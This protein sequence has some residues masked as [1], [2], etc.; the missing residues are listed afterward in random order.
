[1]QDVFVGSFGFQ[2][3]GFG[4]CGLSVSFEPRALGLEVITCRTLRQC[5][6]RRRRARS[7]FPASD[8]GSRVPLGSK[9]QGLGLKVP[10]LGGTK[11]LGLYWGSLCESDY[12]GVIGPG[13]LNQ[14]PTLYGFDFGF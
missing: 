12:F 4:I 13:F 9:L 14:V 5:R 2:V 1:M 10:G 3:F 11:T 7:G 8:R 6:E